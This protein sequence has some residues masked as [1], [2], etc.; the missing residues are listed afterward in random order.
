MG[1]LTERTSVNSRRAIPDRAG[2]VPVH[3]GTPM[4]FARQS[5]RTGSGLFVGH[6]FEQ[7]QPPVALPPVWRCA[8]GFQ[9]DAQDSRPVGSLAVGSVNAR[10]PMGLP[11]Q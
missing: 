10:P 11:S 9:L 2:G 3:C 6:T 8:C 1:P 5:L 4:E 7:E